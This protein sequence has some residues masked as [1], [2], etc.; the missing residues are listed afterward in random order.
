MT[1]ARA[2]G[3]EIQVRL[4]MELNNDNP[5]APRAEKWIEF[6]RLDE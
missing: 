1:P 6:H 2:D 3:R 4:P 5:S